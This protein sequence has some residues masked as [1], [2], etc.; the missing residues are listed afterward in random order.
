MVS[1]VIAKLNKIRSDT[2]KGE[3]SISN[4][5]EEEAEKKKVD[6]A[7]KYQNVGIDT[8]RRSKG[9]RGK[10]STKKPLRRIPPRRL[11]PG[12]KNR[13][14][15]VHR[16]S[17]RSLRKHSD[18][19]IESRQLGRFNTIAKL[20]KFEKIMVRHDINS[21]VKL[22]LNFDAALTFNFNVVRVAK[23]LSFSKIYSTSVLSIVA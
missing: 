19:A 6:T 13:S 23:P 11:F 20:F 3:E 16:E 5:L 17:N 15:N 18:K 4:A 8:S 7:R 1:Y 2:T 10:M 14:Q 9:K 22:Y 12:S 21:A